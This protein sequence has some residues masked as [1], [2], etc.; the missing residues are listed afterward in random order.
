[1]VMNRLLWQGIIMSLIAFNL[2]ASLLLLFCPDLLMKM[3]DIMGKWFST[4]K[5]DEVINKQHNIDRSIIG[6]RKFL[7]VISFLF[8][9]VLIYFYIKIK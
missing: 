8:S 9:I 3:N 7:G 2:I 4:S 5:F 1:M 6:L